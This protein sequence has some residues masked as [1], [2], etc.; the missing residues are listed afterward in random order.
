MK[1]KPILYIDMDEVLADF[2]GNQALEFWGRVKRNP[3]QMYEP[4]FFESLQPLP[5]AIS[6]V[7]QLIQEDNWDIYILTQPVSKSPISY[8]EKANW[9]L[10]WLPEL[11]DK[12]IMTQNKA[13]NI[14]DVLVDDSEKW[15]KVFTGTFIIFRRNVPSITM[16]P[17]VLR[18]LDYILES[19]KH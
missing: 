3:P 17:A 4:G 12:L 2:S 6:S 8:M 7:T 13:L 10:K 19:K 9:I 5:G 18:D 14:G 11:R 1:T 16:W 15:E